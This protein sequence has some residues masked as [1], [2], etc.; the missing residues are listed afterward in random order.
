MKRRDLQRWLQFPNVLAFLK[1][2]RLG[3]GTSGQNGY[4]TLFGGQPFLEVDTHPA[5]RFYETHDEFI[6]NGKLDYTTA[7]GA[8][9]ITYST[10][11]RL[12]KL[13]P[14]TDFS[15]QTQDEMAVALIAGRGALENIKAGQLAT[16][17]SKCAGEW[18][19]LP[20][21]TAGQ[22]TESYAAVEKVYVDAGG[23]LA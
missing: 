11:R 1:A 23:V 6:R 12:C 15:P 20:G 8:Y 2:I 19:S 9:Q 22:R 14:F 16:A 18:A 17:V 4:Y 13:Y 21:S 5:V 7:A 3:E 10:W